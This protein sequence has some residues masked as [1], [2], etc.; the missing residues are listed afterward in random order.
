MSHRALL[1]KRPCYHIN[2]MNIPKHEPVLDV[3][4]LIALVTL[5]EV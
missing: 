3:L 2:L 4:M 5:A 1:S